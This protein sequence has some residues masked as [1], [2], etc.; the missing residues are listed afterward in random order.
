[1]SLCEKA[2]AGKRLCQSTAPG[3]QQQ[4]S[5]GRTEPSAPQ[6]GLLT[7]LQQQN[8]TGLHRQLPPTLHGMA[9]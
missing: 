3:D 9:A 4:R 7:W 1:M 8:Y 5:A 2:V 6:T